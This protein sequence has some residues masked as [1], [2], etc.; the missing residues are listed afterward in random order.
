MNEVY[1][2]G[3]LAQD[4]Q[5]RVISDKLKVA[6]F[7]LA[8]N[9]KSKDKDKST[10]FVSVTAWNRAAEHVISN[11]VKGSYIS[12]KGHINVDKY[13]NKNNEDVVKTTV[14]ADQILNGS[15]PAL[16]KQQN[17]VEGSVA[18]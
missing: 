11:F 13:T 12:F 17:Q 2:D 18:F 1:L 4:P 10:I 6:N 16:N 9:T 5:I 15:L 8:V 14:V 3:R 7:N